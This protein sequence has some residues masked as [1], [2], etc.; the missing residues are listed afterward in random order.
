MLN[1][2]ET[3]GAAI[4]GCRGFERDAEA[5][6]RFR[7]A[8]TVA[9]GAVRGV[10]EGTV[11]YEEV[12]EP[13]RCTIVVAARGDKGAIDGSGA[14]ELEERADA[15][16]VAY[17]GD[18][19]L[20]WPVAGIGQRMAPGISRKLI[21]QTLRNLEGLGREG[22]GTGE[23]VAVTEPAAAGPAAGEHAAKSIPDRLPRPATAASEPFV[24]IELPGRAGLAGGLLVGLALGFLLGRRMR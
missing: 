16:E 23:E 6:H 7:T 18:F 8:I 15:T 22:G 10:Y 2:P 21:V 14:I 4:P 13:K 20:T 11:A 3:L 24:P 12:E 17:R 1:D 19:K 9:V 5:E